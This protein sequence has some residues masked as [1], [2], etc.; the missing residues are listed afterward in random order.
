MRR[1]RSSAAPTEVAWGILLGWCLCLSLWPARLQAQ[2]PAPTGLRELRSVGGITEYQLNNGLQLLLMPAGQHALTRVT[3]T[4]RVG[5]RHE[6]PG[7]AGMAHLLEHVTFRGSR[8]APDL[9]GEMQQ[10]QV[11]W[12]GSTTLDRT[13]Y[14]SWFNTDSPT[15][16]RVLQLEAAR[17]QD[18]LLGQTDFEKEKPIVLNEMGLRATALP[19]QLNH[20]LQA[21]AFRQHPYGR[22]VIGFSADIEGLSLQRLQAFYARHYRPSQAVVMISGA[23]D[24]AAALEA[25]VQAFG[26]LPGDKPHETSGM[27]PVGAAAAAASQPAAQPTDLPEPTQQAPRLTTLRSTQTALAVGF[28]T[29]GMAHPDAAALTVLGRLLLGASARL[30]Q[31]PPLSGQVRLLQAMPL[32]REPNLL[33]LGLM[34]PNSASDSSAARRELEQFED[35]WLLE[36]G[37]F[38]DPRRLGDALVRR[39]AAETATQLRRQL[40]DPDQAAQLISH[41]I[42]AGDWR[43]PFKLLDALPGL[44]AYDVR[45]VASHYVRAEN[46][47]VV[48][49]VTDPRLPST[50]SGEAPQG[51][52]AG[53]FAKP[54]EVPSVQD[55]SQGMER[56]KSG[57]ALQPFAA[58]THPNGS[59]V[60]KP[61][62]SAF[63]P[64]VQRL[65]LPSGIQL[66]L[67]PKANPHEEVTLLLQ[68]RWGRAEE[69]ARLQ[70][71]RALG[72]MLEDGAGRRN[73]AEIRQLRQQLQAD[74][75][76]QSGP[77]GL[78]L[79]L[80]ARRTALLPALELV[81][82]LLQKPTLSDAS[83]ERVRHASLA[84][85][86]PA[87]RESVGTV[88]ERLRR[89]LN[90]QQ[91]LLPGTPDYSPSAA[92]LAQIWREL[93]AEQVRE[94]HQRFW[95][96]K[97]AHVAVVGAL[98]EHL[99]EQLERLFGNWGV[100]SAADASGLGPGTVSSPFTAFVAHRPAHRP[101][102][103]ARFVATL[104]SSGHDAGH[105]D[106]GAAPSSAL[107]LMLHELP[108]QRHA[109]GYLALQLGTRILAGNGEASG[110]R[111]SE[112]LRQQE[113]ISYSV[114]AT[115]RVPSEGDRARLSI[116]A[117]AAPSQVLRLETAMREE[118]SRLLRDGPSDAELERARRQWLADRRQQHGQ[119]EALAASLLTQFDTG[120]N[121]IS[122][123]I[124]EEEQL[125]QLTPAEVLRALRQALAAPGWVTLITGAPSN[126]Q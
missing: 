7:E 85:L 21:S 10:M 73:A 111:L 23:F 66:A 49:A 94:F 40:Q 105:T 48:R 59:A 77:Q 41:A 17:M 119:D 107:V 103:P 87:A 106:E 35:R 126:T 16:R 27:T 72:A 38:A 122:E 13:N 62:P 68:L 43:L 28:R 91:D 15:L 102:A 58:G 101:I 37:Q 65:Q 95:S 47:S 104:A 1:L 46:R 22:P 80:S 31:E 82:D 70:G 25:V 14:F 4:Y 81:R 50:E 114:S 83:F 100:G 89:Y 92:E 39:V 60:F 3:V 116:Q 79:R 113:A 93:R 99:P 110:S 9:A 118:I 71:W 121:F 123:Q 64:T 120:L 33:S 8:Q 97:Q 84:K 57:A 78:Q 88:Q 55:P 42:G 112:R 67:L 76:I 45:R 51:F 34:L 96:A 108:M 11:R 75:R 61:D 52:F 18:A 29:P 44:L 98:P 32:T 74:I 19:Q 24:Q 115:L 86:E 56:I 53:L 69:M 30:V 20:A 36:L 6:G 26:A 5:S 124:A 109:P 90:E 12:N 63:E 54:A 2:T 117:S 125:K